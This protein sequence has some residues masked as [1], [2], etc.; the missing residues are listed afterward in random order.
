M[1]KADNK[2]VKEKNGLLINK[3]DIQKKFSKKF[4]IFLFKRFK[5]F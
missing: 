1:V 4:F 3:D 2:S 5:I